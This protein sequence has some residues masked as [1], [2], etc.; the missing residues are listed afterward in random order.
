MVYYYFVVVVVLVIYVPEKRLCHAKVE[1][2][3]RDW[4][5]FIIVIS[6]K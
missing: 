5:D 6:Y 4:E 2:K 1:G 3:A